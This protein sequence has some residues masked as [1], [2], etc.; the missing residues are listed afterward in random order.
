M[1]VGKFMGITSSVRQNHKEQK[2]Y[3]EFSPG[4]GPLL[5]LTARRVTSANDET[6]VHLGACAAEAPLL[7]TRPDGAFLSIISVA[8]E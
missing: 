6:V 8:Y 5:K 7:R 2:L 1:R 4:N 3:F